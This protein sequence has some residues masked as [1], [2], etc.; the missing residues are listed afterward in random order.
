M[1]KGFSKP[2]HVRQV[3][4]PSEVESRFEA[5]YQLGISPLLGR[6]EELDL[7]LRR[8]EQAKRG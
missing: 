7:L 1:L 2:V 4:G 3:L 6:E 8:W 5:R